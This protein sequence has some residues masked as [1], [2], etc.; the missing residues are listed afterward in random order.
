MLIFIFNLSLT[1]G[2]K[3]FVMAAFVHLSQS[4]CHF[5]MTTSFNS[6]CNVLV[7]ILLKE[8]AMSLYL[9]TSRPPVC[10]RVV[11]RGKF[12]FT[13]FLLNLGLIC[14][15]CCESKQDP[16]GYQANID[17]T[18]PNTMRQKIMLTMPELRRHR[19]VHRYSFLT[20]PLEGV[21]WSSSRP[22][23]FT[24]HKHK[25]ADIH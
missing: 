22:G 7:G 18:R 3:S 23:R 21:K 19:D 24:P 15:S 6:L 2:K 16:L 13:W 14:F 10:L 25:E 4:G 9:Y 20:S 5:C 17:Y 1:F 12:P 8:T 11:D